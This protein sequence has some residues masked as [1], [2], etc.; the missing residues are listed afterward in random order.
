MR[1]RVGPLPSAGVGLWI[2]Y[3]RTVISRTLVRPGDLG[4]EIATDDLEAFERYLEQWERAA[5][6]IEFD[7]EAELDPDEVVRLGTTWLA[8][9]GVLSDE[10]EHRGYPMSP[11]EGEEFYQALIAGF[12]L[13]L[14]HEGGDYAAVACQLRDEWPGL[15]PDQR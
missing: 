13:A 4:V 8:L 2:A 10:A 7:W 11:P 12:L 5:V 6:A 14:E 15:K 9:A 3:A 1:V